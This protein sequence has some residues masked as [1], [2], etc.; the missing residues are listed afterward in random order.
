MNLLPKSIASGIMI[1][2]G[3]T[4]YLVTENK[5]AGALLFTVGLFCICSFGMN[6]F[7]GKIGYVLENKNHPNCL[8]IWVGNF[9]GCIV[10]CSLIRLA[11]PSLADTASQLVANKLALPWYSVLILGF[12]CGILMY[13]AVENFRS[14]PNDF[15]RVLGLFL[16]VSAFIL[17]G[18]EHSV[19]DM[20]YCV[21]AVSDVSGAAR[22]LVFLL[23]VSIANSIGAVFMRKLTL[24]KNA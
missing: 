15:G 5:V 21:F 19:A 12:F 18:F 10:S 8:W 24:A 3:A 2:I 17:C 16:C 11:K 9:L 1:S 6:L 13:L 4:V 7:T 22:S 23:L 14:S 20:C